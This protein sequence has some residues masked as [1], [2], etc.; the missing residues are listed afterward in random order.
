MEG[1]MKVARQ[2]SI[3][4]VCAPRRGCCCRAAAP[5]CPAPAGRRRRPR[6]SPPA[7]A[8]IE[9]R[10]TIEALGTARANESVTLTAKVSETVRKRRASTA[11]TSSR[12]GDVLV[13]LS[14]GAQLAGLEEARAA[15][16]EAEQQLARGQE[17]APTQGHRRA[18]Q[19]D[20][21][22]AT[23]DAA[24]ARMDAMRARLSRPRDHARRSPACSASARSARARW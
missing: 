23:R 19:L 21:Q 11:A 6:S 8:P 24:Q 5:T 3:F 7:V 13:D 14:S 16:Q 4:R 12:A 15:F 22:R 9:W 20:T 2:L 10:D 1:S 18:S 17:L